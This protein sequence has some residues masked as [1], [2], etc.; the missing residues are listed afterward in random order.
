[1]NGQTCELSV[2]STDL[3]VLTQLDQRFSGMRFYVHGMALPHLS[4]GISTSM[5]R[6][7]SLAAQT[8]LQIT[9]TARSALPVFG[10]SFLAKNPEMLCCLP[11]LFPPE[12]GVFAC[13][14]L[15]DIFG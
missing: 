3:N 5:V 8:L 12:G 2:R 14:P 6:V 9:R 1:M 4:L 13:L 11:L 15:P 7:P 10:V